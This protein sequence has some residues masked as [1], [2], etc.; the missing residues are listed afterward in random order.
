MQSFFGDLFK[1][2]L[3]ISEDI[4]KN[5]RNNTLAWPLN[6]SGKNLQDADIEA[7]AEAMRQNHTITELNLSNNKFGG[8]GVRALGR[9]LYT[10]PALTLLDVSKNDIHR[11][12]GG[13]IGI[14][15]QLI[16]KNPVIASL[17]FDKEGLQVSDLKNVD[18]ALENNYIM[19]DMGLFG[20]KTDYEKGYPS[21][22]YSEEPLHNIRNHLSR[23]KKILDVKNEINID[24]SSTGDDALAA[25]YLNFLRQNTKMTSLKIS[26]FNLTFLQ[27]QIFSNITRD[28]HCLKNLVL[29]MYK[30]NDAICEVIFQ[31][32]RDNKSV[33]YLRLLSFPNNK[34]I[35]LL[36]NTLSHHQGIETLEISIENIGDL[37]AAALASYLGNNST[38][39]HFYVHLNT[40]NVRIIQ[41]MIA[42]LYSN[43]TLKTLSLF[44]T[45][46]EPSKE[47]SEVG[48]T[49]SSLLKRNLIITS[50]YLTNM[51]IE[52]SG[53]AALADM[54]SH[55]NSLRKLWIGG[56]KIGPEGATV[57]A[58]AL[59][60]NSGLHLLS[61]E[62]NPIEDLGASALAEM[63]KHNRTLHH[64]YLYG[65]KMS[66]AG[67]Q[68]LASTLRNN[69]G[70]NSIFLSNYLS[71]MQGISEA[72]V[73]VLAES[74]AGNYT[75]THLGIPFGRMGAASI[76]IL[77][78]AI[79]QNH[80]LTNVQ[81]I[82]GSAF[83]VNS[84]DKS[85]L[86]PIPV[87]LIANQQVAIKLHTSCA[88]SD[89]AMVENLISQGVSPCSYYATSDTTGTKSESVLHQAVQRQDKRLIELLLNPKFPYGLGLL[90]M[91]N[92]QDKTA[93][94]IAEE[95]EYTDI[96]ALLLTLE[97]KLLATPAPNFMPQML[98]PAPPEQSTLA[99]PGVIDNQGNITFSLEI[100]REEL[101]WSILLSNK[102]GFGDVYLGMYHREQV[103]I[104]KLRAM[105]L[106][107]STLVE[108]KRET[109]IMAQLQSKYIVR[110]Y[111]IC[112]T[113]PYCMVMEYMPKGA[114]YNILHSPED[115]NW[116]VRQQIAIDI[117]YGL[118]FLHDKNILHKDVKSLNVLLTEQLRA[119]LS[120]FGMSQVRNETTSKTSET[121]TGGTLLW[122]PPES[123]Q[124]KPY[125]P[126][127]DIYSYGVVLWEIATRTLPFQDA[128]GDASL[129]REWI[130]QG[131]YDY[132][133]ETS[134]PA[135]STCP[136]YFQS[137][138]R[139]CWKKEPGQ[140][141]ALH[142][143]IVQLERGDTA[144]VVSGFVDNMLSGP[145]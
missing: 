39:K 7:L 67:E 15:C 34:I 43:S 33:K 72:T 76:Q 51:G 36:A 124:R 95:N 101:E 97:S 50:L 89:Y 88:T 81:R 135:L 46:R 98:L 74:L 78:G 47:E 142:E 8:R 106:S 145:N 120:D 92:P 25:T 70:I 41:I 109:S 140:R 49:I 107:Q 141:M 117:A 62:E 58:H 48:P 131:S 18:N 84:F 115:L 119:K 102:G 64:V 35:Q 96:V 57:L 123:F 28:H 37:G 60:E 40:I 143:A 112:L 132:E 129:I 90:G 54:L 130:T 91:T 3:V 24:I 1:T 104:K 19:I 29:S 56:N 86:Q 127:S 137:V 79:K 69:Q 2:V 52:N 61:L 121:T 6:L 38:L 110:L 116:G 59:K 93:L 94:E 5:I 138:M 118:A 82:E 128:N 27:A 144:P 105:D 108:F 32:L 66:L 53:A 125:T 65:C 13:C 122:K 42:S 9:A 87:A 44:G 139:G 111:G 99:N 73:H 55:N 133:A 11:D 4:L 103:A 68:V 114:L 20:T 26:F 126:K 30:E 85:E 100:K 134:A 77:A 75:L 80:T 113:Q 63:L 21:Y 10:H 71:N 16:R 136:V 17:Y 22:Y 83:Y 45:L 14:L 31:G 12:F 23:N